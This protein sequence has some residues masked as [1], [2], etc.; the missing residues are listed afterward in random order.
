MPAFVRA[1][2]Q[3]CVVDDVSLWRLGISRGE[4]IEHIPQLGLP[5][6]REESLP[7]GAPLVDNVPREVVEV[8]TI[9]HGGTVS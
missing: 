6:I 8:D 9:E 3:A 7:D 1:A 4:P 5:Q 2:R